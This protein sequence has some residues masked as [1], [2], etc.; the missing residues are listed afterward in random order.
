MLYPDSARRI[1][2]I[3]MMASVFENEGYKKTA[4]EIRS[5]T[6]IFQADNLSM[7]LLKGVRA[8]YGQLFY[9]FETEFAEKPRTGQDYR[10]RVFDEIRELIFK[11]IEKMDPEFA[12][13]TIEIFPILTSLMHGRQVTSD[14]SNAVK[15]TNLDKKIAFHLY[16]Y[17]YLIIVEGIFDELARILFFFKNVTKDNIPKSKDLKK[18]EVWKI[19]KSFGFVPVFLENWKEKKSI[20]NAIGHATVFYDPSK[21]EAQFVDEIS[22]YDKTL[23]LNQFIQIL[24]ELED[25]VAA[26][27]H[28]MI[29]LRLYD[30]ILS[31]KP[32]EEPA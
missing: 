30:F 8:K 18:M 19:L 10:K 20:R 15:N 7:D 22:G 13:A 21:D 29:L 23:N 24:A 3:H 11:A 14:I 28:V 9:V 1:A 16:C 25:S 2:E 26:F 31:S 27:T 6:G 5:F 12:R 17:A 32:F 4:S